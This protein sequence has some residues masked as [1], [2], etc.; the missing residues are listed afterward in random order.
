MTPPVLAIVQARMASTRLPGKMLLPLGDKPLIQ[1]A[2]DATVEAFGE[3]RTLVAICQNEANQPLIDYLRAA[4]VWLAV[5]N[6]D[7]ADVLGRLVVAANEVVWH[8]DSVIVRVTPDDP[9]KDPATMRLVARGYRYPVEVGAEACTYGELLKWN[10]VFK[11]EHIREHVGELFTPGGLYL[12]NDY[13][14]W[15]V[16]TPE[17]YER[18]KLRAANIQR[19]HRGEEERHSST[20]I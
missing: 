17:D 20:A 14:V 4:G 11:D 19:R 8:P 7:E 18:A 3:D 9:F 6:L 13:V 5:G 12:G 1:W 2:I 10:S 16:D 15:T